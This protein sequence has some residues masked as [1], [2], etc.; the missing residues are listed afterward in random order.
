MRKV[1][2][3][4]C[5][6]CN[7]SFKTLT[8]FGDHMQKW[9]PDEIPNGWS[10][11]RYFYY[12]Q[13]GKMHGTC[14]VC[15]R[16]SEWNEA[17]GK[18][19]RFCENPK[20]K[21]EYREEFKKRMIGKYGKTHLLNDPEKQKEMLK[22]RKI[23]GTYSFEDGGKIDYVG[24]YEKDFLFMLDQFMHFNS[25]D[26]M[27]PSPHTYYYA[28]RN[29]KDKKN[30]GLK[31]YIPDFYIPSLNL[32]VEIKDTTNQHHKIID[33]DRVKEKLKDETMS[34]I[35]KL[36]YLKITDK[37]YESFFEF[38]LNMKEQIDD[39]R[40]EVIL[41]KA[42]ESILS[43]IIESYSL[44]DTPEFNSSEDLLRYMK[45]N[46][47][48]SEFKKLKT[49]EEVIKTKSGSCHDQVNLEYKVL[50][51]LGYKP[52][53]LFFIAFKEESDVGGMT[54]SLCYYE[55]DNKVYWFEN[56][57]EDAK[58]LRKYNSLNELKNDIWKRYKKM[59]ESK[60]FPELEFKII[61]INHYK[62]GI[63][64]GE[65]VSSIMD[66]TANEAYTES[67]ETDTESSLYE[68]KRYFRYLKAIS[69]VEIP[70]DT[71]IMKSVVTCPIDGR[72]DKC[73]FNELADAVCA[74]I[75]KTK[76]NTKFV[77]RI[78]NNKEFYDLYSIKK[79]NIGDL[80]TINPKDNMPE[81]FTRD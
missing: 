48:Y 10:V 16:D 20:C 36:N 55:K 15:K 56:S 18:Y 51:K 22:A 54:H 12:L 34:N 23:S 50:S 57:W 42:L 79:I 66:S 3:Y 27:G 64:L 13:T 80:F 5:P 7:K 37:N 61:G 46:I 19:N 17:T 2:V 62:T 35:P 75:V 49:P 59:E 33:I 28:Y 11:T 43:P 72:I 68:I 9:H 77:K 63:T 24:T 14:I 41:N 81:F 1:K 45:V 40:D 69:K 30:E 26:I 25:K 29:P 73:N 44:K 76:G 31:F 74:N 78:E 60:N 53:I 38:L 71:L 4:K 47:K 21:E 39:R 67:G 65:F 8:G 58:G 32:E 52:K 70:E 6:I